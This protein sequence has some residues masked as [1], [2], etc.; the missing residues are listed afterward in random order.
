MHQSDSLTFLP[1]FA[2]RQRHLQPSRPRKWF[3]R[4]A[5]VWLAGELGLVHRHEAREFLEPVMDEDDGQLLKRRVE[6]SRADGLD[7]SS[8]QLPLVAEEPVA[9]PCPYLS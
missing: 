1:T 8:A 4:R 3:R 5:K 9:S 7:L 2:T 6:V